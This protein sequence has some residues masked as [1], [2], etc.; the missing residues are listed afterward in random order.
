MPRNRREHI[1]MNFRRGS[2]EFQVVRGFGPIKVVCGCVARL[3]EL[4]WSWGG[5]SETCN[6]ARDGERSVREPFV[7]KPLQ[8]RMR[9]DVALA[10]LPRARHREPRLAEQR[11]R[12]SVFLFKRK[13]LV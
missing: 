8:L 5:G 1:G 10:A 4:P 11:V 13:K 9:N 12:E 7:R 6:S 2:A 3:R